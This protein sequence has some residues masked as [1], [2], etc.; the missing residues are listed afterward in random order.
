MEEFHVPLS[1]EWNQHKVRADTTFLELSFRGWGFTSLLWTS[2]VSHQHNNFSVLWTLSKSIKL[3]PIQQAISSV[4]SQHCHPVYSP[5]PLNQSLSITVLHVPV[6]AAPASFRSGLLKSDYPRTPMTYHKHDF[7]LGTY[8]CYLIYH[9][10]FL[11]LKFNAFSMFL[12]WN[13][14][15]HPQKITRGTA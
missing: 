2:E 5:W 1:K 3:L 13:S 4:I 14:L 15:H 9:V 11:L 8:Y 10:P 7:H 12:R 6:A